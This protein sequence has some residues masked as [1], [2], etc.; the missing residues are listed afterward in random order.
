MHG[1]RGTSCSRHVKI[2]QTRLYRQNDIR[3]KLLSR[4]AGK[5]T[6][7]SSTSAAV[8]EA[9]VAVDR[10]PLY[11]TRREAALGL[12]SGLR[13]RRADSVAG[14]TS[15]KFRFSTKCLFRFGQNAGGNTKIEVPHRHE[16]RI[17]SDL[18]RRAATG[19][20]RRASSV[21]GLNSIMEFTYY[22][23]RSYI[24]INTFEQTGVFFTE[25][26]RGTA[27]TA[28]GLAQSA[29]TA[30]RMGWV[31]QARRDTEACLR[32]VRDCP[33]PPVHSRKR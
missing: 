9:V 21:C 2:G 8:L 19:L 18:F 16:L 15:Q 12:S 22:T 33:R 10:L 5:R 11:W 24:S 4:Q 30:S 26:A 7:T 6:H 23:S 1:L 14:A 28:R 13:Q 31:R 25:R 32:E 20:V 3:T 17:T 27:H 29:N